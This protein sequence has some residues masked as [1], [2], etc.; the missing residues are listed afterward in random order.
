MVAAILDQHNAPSALADVNVAWNDGMTSRYKV[1]LPPP[2]SMDIYIFCAWLEAEVKKQAGVEPMTPVR[3]RSDMEILELVCTEGTHLP[4]RMAIDMAIAAGKRERLRGALRRRSKLC[5][6]VSRI[7]LCHEP[8]T[9]RQTAD[10]A[11]DPTIAAVSITSAGGS[12]SPSARMRHL[13]LK[14]AAGKN[15]SAQAAQCAWLALEPHPNVLALTLTAGPNLFLFQCQHPACSNALE[16]LHQDRQVAVLP[17]TARRR[18]IS[19]M[20]L[21]VAMAVQ[22]MHG[23]GALH[24]DLKPANVLV[25]VRPNQ[26]N[27]AHAQ[28]LE[29]RVV[30][31]LCDWELVSVYQTQSASECRTG[32]REAP[33]PQTTN[34]KPQTPNPKPQTPN[35]NLSLD[36]SL[37]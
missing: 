27:G 32:G 23:E 30:C 16:W 4:Y 20:L 11:R 17:L 24:L 13:Y 29:S 28:A 5:N 1:V 25:Q 36:T 19:A 7:S 14:I 21:Q 15:S 35:P 26:D 34:H 37:T 8:S 10:L 3:F 12:Q 33:K 6:W 18:V 22:F 2:S 9:D 31:Q